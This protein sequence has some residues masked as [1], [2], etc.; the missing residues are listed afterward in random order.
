MIGGLVDTLG[1]SAA[2]LGLLGDDLM[3]LTL[4]VMEISIENI[5]GVCVGTF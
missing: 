3:Q 5:D 2:V 4:E 1:L